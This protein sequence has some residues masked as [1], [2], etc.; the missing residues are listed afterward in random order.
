MEISDISATVQHLE[1]HL[2]RMSKPT[3]KATT[4]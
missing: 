2:D 3:L 1:D 4:D